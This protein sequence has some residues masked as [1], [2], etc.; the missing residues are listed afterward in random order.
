MRR[1]IAILFSFFF[2]SAQTA[3]A[4]VP[5]V[6]PIQ[7]LEKMSGTDF[8][9]LFTPLYSVNYV[10]M[11]VCFLLILGALYFLGHNVPLFIKEFSYI[12]R[13]L[14]SYQ[15]LVPWILR[16]GLGIL[17]MGAALHSVFI[18]PILTG[19]T[20]LA[21]YELII[22]FCLLIGFLITPSL[23]IAIGFYLAS[24]IQNGYMIGSIEVLGASI[25]L[26]L[27]AQTRPSFDDIVGIPMLIKDR[28]AKYA[29]LILRISLGTTFIFLAFY[30]KIFNPHYFTFVV[31]Q[32][33]LTSIIHVSP[34]MW[35]LAV[36]LIELI[37]GIC[38]LFGFKTRITAVIAF[39]VFS[40]SFFF[41]KE[42]VYSHVTIFAILTALFV[43][44]GGH[45]SIDEH[46]EHSVGTKG[47]IRLR[48]SPRKI[49]KRKKTIVKRSKK[50]A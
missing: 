44:G 1:T 11:M 19:Y 43:T 40:A 6:V 33:N 26:L 22:G 7:L 21:A 8:L 28:Y 23:L 45:W 16:L 39:C 12:K 5:Y 49:A 41:F 37:V 36:G 47:T 2:L 4:H 24:L 46:I 15:D 30:E 32:Y 29:P 35:T 42:D 10:V 50:L 38:I 31:N 34:S 27:L 20:N 9:F 14:L 3:S 17:F 13:K 18:S 48:R 25:A